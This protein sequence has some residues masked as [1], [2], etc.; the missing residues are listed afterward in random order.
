VGVE[1]ELIGVDIDALSREVAREVGG[2]VE[3]ASRYEHLVHGDRHGDWKIELDFLY[4]KEKGRESREEAG[5][6]PDLDA[7]AERLLR[8]GAE[9]IV[10]Y[11]VVSPPLP[12]TELPRLGPL[13]ER[14]RR[15]GAR[16]TTDGV[17]YAFGMQLNPEMPAT[18]A[19]TLLRYLQAF[20]C[21]FDW[22]K[23]R[24][25]V[26]LTRRLTAYVAP[27]PKPYVRAVVDPG[28]GPD[29]PALIDDYLA[30][31]PTRNRPLDLLP[32]L[33]HLDP[34]R[35]RRVVDDP[36]VKPRP[37]LHYRL[38]NCEIDRPGWGV[39]VAWNDWLQ[40]ER[41]AAEPERLSSLCALYAGYLD[42]PLGGLLEDWA[43]RLESWIEAP[44]AP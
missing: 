26:D 38:P 12:V 10:P 42:K 39:H 40:V 8:A 27:F 19:A 2:A 30:A 17:L 33:L 36:L 20:L 3:R 44:R 32:L 25:R 34:E 7:T 1:L 16:G 28:Y 22:L 24:A 41:L 4:L 15:A 14:L 21:L 18:D 37:A 43:K 11:E 6:L 35:V 13:V 9:Q 29:L 5:L 31:N 23:E